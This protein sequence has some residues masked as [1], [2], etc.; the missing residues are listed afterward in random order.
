MTEQLVLLSTYLVAVSLATERLVTLF[1]FPSLSEEK[2]DANGNIIQREEKW[3]T[4]KVQLMSLVAAYIT[5]SLLNNSFDPTEPICVSEGSGS[6]WPAGVVALLSTGGSAFWNSV[7]GYASAV[8]DAKKQEK[9]Q[10]KIVLM[11]LKEKVLN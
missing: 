4:F 7:L 6:C 2:R 3:R 8:K 1:K 9:E 10:Q 11:E 5:V